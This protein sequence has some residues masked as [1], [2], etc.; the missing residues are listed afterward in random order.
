MYRVLLRWYPPIPSR[1]ASW[2]NASTFPWYRSL[3]AQSLACHKAGCVMNS[4]VKYSP[5]NRVRDVVRLFNSQRPDLGMPNNISGTRRSVNHYSC[6]NDPTACHS[7]ANTIDQRGLSF[8]TK[9]QAEG[10]ED[11]MFLRLARS[12]PS[13]M[14]SK[15]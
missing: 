5:C 10:P 14:V 2:R 6:R 4:S 11:C 3:T 9:K 12:L 15:L 1:A 7:G 13:T 8:A